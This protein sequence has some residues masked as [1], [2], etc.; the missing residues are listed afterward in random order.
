MERRSR[1]KRRSFGWL[2]FLI[3]VLVVL[4]ALVLIGYNSLVKKPRKAYAQTSAEIVISLQEASVLIDKSVIDYRNKQ[5]SLETAKFGLQDA[6]DIVKESQDKLLSMKDISSLKSV[7]DRLNSSINDISKTIDLAYGYLDK[8]KI[9]FDAEDWINYLTQTRQEFLKKLTE[10]GY[11]F[12]KNLADEYS[13]KIDDRVKEFQAIQDDSEQAF[14]D[15]QQ[16][17]SK[18]EKP[19]AELEPWLSY[20]VDLESMRSKETENE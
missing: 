20:F 7:K 11:D 13:K 5:I 15:Y 2:Y 8:Q 4:G 16:S 17:Y 18:I 14:I 19:L 6:S 12:Y 3:I 9:S 1:R 10:T